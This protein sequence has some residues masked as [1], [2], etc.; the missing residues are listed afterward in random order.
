MFCAPLA[1]FIDNAMNLPLDIYDDMPREMKVYLRNNGFHFNK[2]SVTSAIRLMRR[3][4]ATTGKLEPIEIT[5]KEQIEQMLKNY[6]VSIEENSGY[7]FVYYFHQAQADLY[8]SSIADERELCLYVS[9]MIN[10]PD[11]PGGNAF[12]HFLVDLDAKGIGMDWGD[13]L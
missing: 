7:D 12:R 3:K 6:G 13:W 2:K 11:M 5:P 9:D 10:D 4:N 1:L 8:K